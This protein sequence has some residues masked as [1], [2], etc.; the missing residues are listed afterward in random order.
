MLKDRKEEAVTTLTGDSFL[1]GVPLASDFDLELFQG[2]WARRFGQEADDW[3]AVPN[4]CSGFAWDG[5][6]DCSIPWASMKS[7][8]RRGG[9][10]VCQNCSEPTLLVN[11]GFRQ[12][13]MFNRFSCFDYLCG[14]CHRLFRDETV[15]VKA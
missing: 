2:K 15:D 12:V 5:L 10:V 14:T 13:G 1:Y 11:F 6:P 4:A 7:A 8:W 3:S 9:G